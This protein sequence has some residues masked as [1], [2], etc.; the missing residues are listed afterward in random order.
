MFD[1]SVVQQHVPDT[2]IGTS[3][4]DEELAALNKVTTSGK[5]KCTLIVVLQNK[6]GGNAEK[7]QYNAFSKIIC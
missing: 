7:K 2:Y 4:W 1:T 3:W 6:D 5:L